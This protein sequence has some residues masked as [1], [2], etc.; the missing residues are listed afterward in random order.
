MIRPEPVVIAID[1]INFVAADTDADVV[2]IVLLRQ[3]PA[4]LRERFDSQLP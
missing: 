2:L 3:K 4:C 1:F